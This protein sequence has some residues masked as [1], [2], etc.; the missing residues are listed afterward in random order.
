MTPLLIGLGTLALVSF[1]ISALVSMMWR[2][3]NP[4]L[5]RIAPAAEARLLLLIVVIANRQANVK[6]SFCKSYP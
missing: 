1:A 4:V 6:L 2:L 3:L 5:R